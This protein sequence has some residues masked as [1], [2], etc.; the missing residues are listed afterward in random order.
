MKRIFTFINAFFRSQ[1]LPASLLVAGN[2]L[3]IQPALLYKNNQFFFHFSFLEF[4]MILLP[5][6]LALFICLSLPAI[7]NSATWKRIYTVLLTATAVTLWGATFFIGSQGVLDGKSF[8]M[9]QDAK[10]LWINTILLFLLFIITTFIAWYGK[11]I[12]NYFI[13]I[14]CAISLFPMGW[15]VLTDKHGINQVNSKQNTMPSLVSFS[16]EKNVLVLILD[17]F[18]SDFFQEMM[19]SNPSWLNELSGFTYY[20][21]AI[22]VAPTTYLSI[23]SIH[24]GEV[25]RSGEPVDSFYKRTVL[26]N[27]FMSSHGKNGYNAFVLNPY[28]DYCSQNA[29]CINQ[30]N[31]D[32]KTFSKELALLMDMSIFRLSPHLAKPF[33]YNNGHWRLSDKVVNNKERAEISNEMLEMLAKNINVSS[34]IPTIKLLHLYGTHAPVVLNKKCHRVSSPWIREA[35]IDQD[36]CAMTYVLNV[37][38]ALKDQH[39]YDQTA[40]MII[41]DHGVGMPSSHLNYLSAAASP[42]FLFKPFNS[43]GLMKTSDKLV[44]LTDIPATLCAMTN[45]C[46]KT[47]SFGEDIQTA[48]LDKRK[49]HFNYYDWKDNAIALDKPFN[50]IMEYEVEGSPQQAT[51]WKRVYNTALA[52]LKKTLS[53]GDDSFFSNYCGVGWE[54]AENHQGD[55]KRWVIGT[56]AELFLPLPINKNATLGFTISTHQFNSKQHLAVFVN[57][58]LIEKYPIDFKQHNNIT[59]QIPSHIITKEPTNIVFKFD[60]GISPSSKDIRPLAALFL[61]EIKIN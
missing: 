23:P 1:A 27:S 61:G 30:E 58:I 12:I 2:L 38:K 31:F 44:S 24:S 26:T 7:G 35:A 36:A 32:A 40:I 9:I 33:V 57:N 28:M 45:D 25:Y 39:I 14:I 52:P 59:L 15:V 41:A 47:P 56:T 21:E 5:S 49:F 8:S 53:V 37:I 29:S 20:D 22:G 34:N 16:K 13:L 50:S 3:L 54:A 60:Q 17:S 6:F 19:T 46:Q 10:N 4:L 55:S 11:R 48:N 42:L 18:Q 51:S 43:V